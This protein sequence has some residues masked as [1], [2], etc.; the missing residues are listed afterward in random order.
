MNSNEMMTKLKDGQRFVMK[1]DPKIVLRKAYDGTYEMVR[2]LA[3]ACCAKT[4]SCMG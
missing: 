3:F 2:P 4:M 1:D